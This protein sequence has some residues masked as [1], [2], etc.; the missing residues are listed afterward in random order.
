MSEARS[1]R[2]WQI[3]YAAAML[4]SDSTQVLQRIE[5]AAEAICARLKELPETFSVRSEHVELQSALNYLRR[6]QDSLSG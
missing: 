1:R 3:L 2:D 6:V 5:R 4:E